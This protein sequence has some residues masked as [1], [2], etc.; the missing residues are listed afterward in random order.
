MCDRFKKICDKMSASGYGV[1]HPE[2]SKS[3]QSQAEKQFSYFTCLEKFL[4][5]KSNIAAVFVTQAGARGSDI[6]TG[7]K[8]RSLLSQG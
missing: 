8:E 7:I 3:L 1:R 5:E 6:K 4:L 2:T